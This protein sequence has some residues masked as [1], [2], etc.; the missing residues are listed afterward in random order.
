MSPDP[1]PLILFCLTEV[2]DDFE[3]IDLEEEV[4]DE[5]SIPTPQAAPQAP[6]DA[7][8]AGTDI[9]QLE[10]ISLGDPSYHIHIH[11]TS[12]GRQKCCISWKI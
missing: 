5:D 11:Q 12:Q 8:K 9:G 1:H 2:I 4:P 3:S 10:W 6:T 7:S